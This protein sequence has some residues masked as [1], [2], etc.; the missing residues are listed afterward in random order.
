[1][2][3]STFVVAFVAFLV[4]AGLVGLIGMKVKVGDS[5]SDRLD[6][7]TNRG[8][9]ND[10]SSDNVLK[11]ALLD[12]DK[13]SILDMLTP[14]ILN[15]SRYFE[16]ADVHVKP[17][18]LFAL[19]IM[20]GFI[21][22]VISALLAR[23]IYVAPVGGVILFSQPWLWLWWR[24]RARLNKFANQLSD[25]MELIAR[26][27]RAG[28]S[29]AAGLHVVAEEMPPPISKEFNRIYEEQNLGIS[30]EDAMRGV[31]ERVPNL[32]LKFFVTAV[33]IQRQT[34]GDLAEILDKIGYVIRERAKIIG[35]VKALTGEGRLSGL[36]LMLLPAALFLFMLHTKYEYIS[37][38]WT[39]PMG[40]KMSVYAL[41]L[42]VV[43]AISIKKIVDIKV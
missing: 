26:A 37:A 13:K 36:V 2:V 28:H 14:K 39:D 29:L 30:L 9:R 5:S 4:V 20:S 6:R 18:S 35:Q 32:D 27:L 16:Q 3:M 33:L 41:I 1:M 7:L 10:S 17:S 34:G 12:V 38:L 31:C 19:S 24:R 21:G 43:G 15:Y 11:Q 25:A 23:N 8:G 40:V 42:Q 22:A